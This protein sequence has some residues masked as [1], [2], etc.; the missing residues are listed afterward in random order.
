MHPKNHDDVCLPGLIPCERRCPAKNGPKTGEESAALNP[1]GGARADQISR[2]R[3]RGLRV[4]VA[5]GWVPRAEVLALQLASLASCIDCRQ[6][7]KPLRVSVAKRTPATLWSDGRRRRKAPGS[8]DVAGDVGLAGSGSCEHGSG[9][10]GGV[11]S[12]VPRPA[13]VAI[14][15]NRASPCPA[16]ERELPSEAKRIAFGSNFNQSI[17]GIRWPQGL[18]EISFGSK[19]SQPIEG[20]AWPASLKKISFA[21]ASSFDRPLA[22][23]VWPESLQDISFGVKFNQ[24]LGEGE[25]CWPSKLERITLRSYKRDLTGVSWPPSLRGLKVG[26]VFDL[27]I[28]GIHLPSGLQELEISS[29]FNHPIADVAF[30]ATLKTLCFGNRFNQPIGKVAWPASLQRLTFG[31]SFDQPL[32]RVRLPSG[33]THL[34]F[35]STVF[36]QPLHDVDWPEGL[37]ELF[38]GDGFN[39][40]LALPRRL[41]KIVFGDRFNKPVE[42]LSWNHGLEEVSFGRNF[43][44]PIAGV[45][46]PASLRRLQCGARFKQCLSGAEWPPAFETLDLSDCHMRWGCGPK[47]GYEGWSPRIEIISRK[48]V[49][50]LGWQRR[51]GAGCIAIR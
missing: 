21:D 32:E 46:W 41:R 51:G 36:N 38:L 2:C 45:V 30:P 50:S 48:S 25:V 19:F 3:D 34:S 49:D 29:T 5:S 47:K 14:V 35:N 17:S 26:G 28:D 18:E 1:A 8:A 24:G 4:A 27:P 10:G 16:L 20:V 22:E 42:G 33:L 31:L 37:T 11:E 15:W 23:V 44:Q 12:R 6:A 40:S 7:Q 13:I 9:G 39:S 43:N